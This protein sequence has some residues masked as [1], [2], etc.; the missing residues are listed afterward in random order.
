MLCPRARRVWLRPL[1]ERSDARPYSSSDTVC[2]HPEYRSVR[3]TPL[4]Q[5]DPVTRAGEVVARGRPLGT[6]ATGRPFA[7]VSIIGREGAVRPTDDADIMRVYDA[8]DNWER[9]R[10]ARELAAGRGVSATQI[11]L[12]YVLHQSFP[13]FPIMGPLTLEEFR[14]SGAVD[15]IALS[16]SEVR[17]LNLEAETLG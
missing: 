8:E 1:R 13:A 2:D 10:R 17:W 5:T 9:L 16:P 4:A 14:V 12:A 3:R 7:K 11:A 15:D 6:K